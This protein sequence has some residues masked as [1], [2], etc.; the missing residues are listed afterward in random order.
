MSSVIRISPEVRDRLEILKRKLRIKS[1][2]KLLEIIINT[3]EKELDRWE[4]DPDVFFESLRF[5]GEAGERDSE[6]VDEL[7]YRRSED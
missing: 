7:L 4:G 6:Q 1:M 5:S 2:S 3:A